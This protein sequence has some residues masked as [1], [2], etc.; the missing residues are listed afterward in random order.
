M[1]D[2]ILT[3]LKDVL[4]DLKKIIDADTIIIGQSLENDLHAL[5]LIHGRVIDTSVLYITRKGSKLP[6]KTLSYTH[7][8]YSIQNVINSLNL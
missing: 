5:K 6:L 7:L 4:E 3:T 1:L 8:K 2:N